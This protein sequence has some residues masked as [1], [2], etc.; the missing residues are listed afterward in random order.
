[1]GEWKRI[2]RWKIRLTS[3]W[4]CLTFKYFVLTAWIK[5]DDGDLTFKI[6]H[7]GV[8]PAD[9]AHRVRVD[10]AEILQDIADQNSALDEVEKIIK[11]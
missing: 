10:A 5:D 1:M 6:T 8:T 4:R 9:A 3:A 7:K 11:V 2:K